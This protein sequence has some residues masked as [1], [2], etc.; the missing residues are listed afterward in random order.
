MK[1]TIYE[2]QIASFMSNAIGKKSQESLEERIFTLFNFLENSDDYRLVEAVKFFIE[3]YEFDID[4]LPDRLYQKVTDDLIDE[5]R[6]S[7]YDSMVM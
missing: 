7:Y 4:V 5:R 1:R 3:N 2:Y 6:E